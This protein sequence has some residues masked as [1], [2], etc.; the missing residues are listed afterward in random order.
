MTFIR[1]VETES[2]LKRLE[3]LDKSYLRPEFV[4]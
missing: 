2:D 3:T 1:P 4:N